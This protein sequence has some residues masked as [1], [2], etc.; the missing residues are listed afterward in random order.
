MKYL[1]TIFYEEAR[2]TE[3]PSPDLN[4]FLQACAQCAHE[5]E[6][7]GHLLAAGALEEVRTAVSVR[8]RNGKVAISDGPFAETKEQLGGFCL[9]EARDLNEAIQIAQSMPPAQIGTV[10]V[11]PLKIQ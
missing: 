4:N 5:L 8:V 11:R 10:E 7:K 6:S 1:C 3:M 9:L 2:L